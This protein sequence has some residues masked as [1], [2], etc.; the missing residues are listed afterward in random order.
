M[1][2]HAF[3]HSLGKSNAKKGKTLKLNMIKKAQWD[4]DDGWMVNFE[5]KA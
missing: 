4:W 3:I 2:I 1:V 5:L